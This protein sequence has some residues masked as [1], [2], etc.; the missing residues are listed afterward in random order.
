M[1][2]PEPRVH[3]TLQSVTTASGFL[4]LA[5][6]AYVSSFKARPASPK[7]EPCAQCRWRKVCPNS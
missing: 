6:D 2:R 5:M 4:H 3:C 7:P 1:A